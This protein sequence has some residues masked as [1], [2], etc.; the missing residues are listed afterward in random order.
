MAGRHW[1]LKDAGCQDSGSET[2][3]E[4]PA[5]LGVD[6][7]GVVIHIP[8]V[9]VVIH[10]VAHGDYSLRVVLLTGQLRAM[11]YFCTV[12]CVEK[13]QAGSRAGSTASSL[14]QQAATMTMPLSQSQ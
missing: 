10:V 3:S 7:I 13:V 12:D 4:I 5:F 1:F 6:V 2:H 9:I 14:T 8:V 11:C